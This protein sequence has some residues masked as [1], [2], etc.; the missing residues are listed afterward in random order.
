MIECA[1]ERMKRLSS[2]SLAILFWTL[3]TPVSASAAQ[4]YGL[5][6]GNLLLR[7]DS[8]TPGSILKAWAITG[9]Q[10]GEIIQAIDFRPASGQLYGLGSSNRLYILNTNS[11]AAQT[12]SSAGAFTLS[13][14]AFGFDVNPVA[15]RIRVVSD[16]DQNIRLNPANGTLAATDTALN[17][18]NPNVVALAYD[19]N[20]AGAT[21]TTLY[22]IDSGTDMLVLLNP[23]NAGTLIPVGPLGF[24]TS[25]VCG[26]DISPSG[27]AFAA[28]TAPGDFSPKLF[29]INLATGQATLMGNIGGGATILDIAVAPTPMVRFSSAQYSATEPSGKATISLTRF[30]GSQ[31]TMSVNYSTAPGTATPNADYVPV[32]GL[33][34]FTNGEINKSFEVPILNDNI[35]ELNET[36]LLTLS[37]SATNGP[38]G[39]ITNAILEIVS[40]QDLP[41]YL[42]TVSNQLLRF[43]RSPGVIQTNLAITGLLAG[44]VLLAMDFRPASGQLY[45]LG[46]SNRLYTLNPNS[47]AA[48]MVGSPGAFTLV[49]TD[50]GF[51]FNPSVDRIRVT[52]DAKQN[53]RLNPSDGSLVATDSALAYAVGDLHSGVNPTIVA[54]AYNNNFAGAPTTTLYGIDSGLDTLVVQNPPNNGTL[55]TIGAL[56]VDISAPAGLDISEADQDAYAVFKRSAASVSEIYRVNLNTGTATFVGA[57]N[58]LALIR[59]IAIPEPQ[60]VLEIFRAGTN[61][62]LTWSAASF[63]Y[64]LEKTPS[65]IAPAWDTNLPAP[66]II[67]DQK[68]VT[69]ALVTTNR[70]FRLKK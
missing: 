17:P 41:M 62:V 59:D 70:F 30:N 24:N 8:A 63:G 55:T 27:E 16:T 33:I 25:S 23:P 50:F 65:L 31:G 35:A 69:N 45:G 53:F 9:L 48:T 1:I 13:G 64:V 57:V 52:S 56:G 38:V 29:Q 54:S 18:S 21:I 43:S 19:N 47:G 28:M 4:I 32:S 44:E 11:G 3:A 7:F 22:G 61:A 5:T 6:T 46:S 51:D 36:V 14:T 66:V 58:S 42:L 2:L 10:S 67:N 39:G 26:F 15:D 34:V 40:A 12:V 20:F 37:A 60:P 68:V 49:G